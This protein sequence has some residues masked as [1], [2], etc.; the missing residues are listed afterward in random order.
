VS[1]FRFSFCFTTKNVK[2]YLLLLFLTKS[3]EFRWNKKKSFFFPSLLKERKRERERE[4]E[5]K[6]SDEPSEQLIAIADV[7]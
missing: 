3:K 5:K 1:F 6:K 4:R 2:D 7:C